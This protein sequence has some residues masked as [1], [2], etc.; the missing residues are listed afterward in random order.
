M[1]AVVAVAVV[2]TAAARLVVGIYH[3]AACPGMGRST[4]TLQ[5]KLSK[6]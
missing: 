1:M 4:M 5:R 2:I 3:G 6:L